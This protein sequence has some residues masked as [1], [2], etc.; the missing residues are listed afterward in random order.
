MFCNH[1]KECQATNETD[2]LGPTAYT[3]SRLYLLLKERHQICLLRCCW[4]VDIVLQEDS[5]VS[6]MVDQLA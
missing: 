6:I 3:C 5:A 2:A 1:R 4:R